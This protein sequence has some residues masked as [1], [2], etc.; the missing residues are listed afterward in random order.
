MTELWVTRRQNLT[1]CPP[2]KLTFPYRALPHATITS[3]EY[4]KKCV[5]FALPFAGQIEWHT[6]IDYRC[7]CPDFELWQGY[8]R[9]QPRWWN[10]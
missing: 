7:D 3:N 6:S 10:R 5:V 2:W 9:I 8:Q 4:H 1:Y